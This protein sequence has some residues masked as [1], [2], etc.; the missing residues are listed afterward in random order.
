MKNINDKKIKILAVDD[1]LVNI[2]IL[3]QFL[4]KQSYEVI[5][6]ESGEEAIELF[7]A[8]DP[9]IILMDVMMGGMSG[10]EAT[11]K[12]KA[13]SG[14]KWV[15]VIFM[16]ALASEE[17]KIKG[18]DVGD[19]YITKPV[20]FNILVAKLKA[21][22][23]IADIQFKL[24]E[25]TAEL[26][27]YKKAEESEQVMAHELMNSLFAGGEC[28]GQDFHIWH[29][30]AT[31]FSGDL[32]VAEKYSDDRLYLLHADS[33]G[34]GLTAAL[35]LLPISQTFYAM[36]KEGYSIGQIA[37]NMNKQLKATM[38]INRF[39][40]VSLVLIDY[41]SNVV[42][43]WNGGNPCVFAVNESNEIVKRFDSQHLA[44]G[45][46]PDSDF[47]TNTDFL[48]CEG[49][50]TLVIYSDGL[51][52]AENREGEIFDED[53]LLEI[54]KI[55]SDAVK[56]RNNIVEA[57]SNHLDGDKAHDDMSLVVVNTHK[58]QA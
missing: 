2:K 30:P 16:S 1:N 51:T 45:I 11:A 8:E 33:T 20:E 54:L 28:E 37:R 17:D 53:S 44:L 10:L 38:P 47:D 7:K 24:S 5:T 22:Q 41:S 50:N 15:P 39:V 46:L 14:D 23:R 21:V 35:P 6:A 25:T 27:Q 34:H 9:Q 31:R 55:E 12:I 43:V 29:I 42:E 3:S 36:A 18:L 19:D 56:L 48:V 52:E 58:S 57:V 13:L 40:A 26:Q 32:I 49:S 4:L